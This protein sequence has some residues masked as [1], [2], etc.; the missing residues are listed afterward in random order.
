VNLSA[1]VIVGAMSG[2]ACGVF[3]GEYAAVLEP[4]GA[5]YVALLQ[6]VVFPFIVASLLHGLGSLR[7]RTAL[8]LLRSGWLVFVVAWAGTLGSLWLLAQA[9]PAGRSPIVVAADQGH[10]AAQLVSLLIPANPFADLTRNYVPAIVVFSVFYG[11][12]MQGI[13]KR[14]GVLRGLDVVRR[15]SVTIWS[16]VVRLAPLGVFA[17]FADLAGT[18]RLDLLGSLLL[19]AVLFVGGALILALWVIPSLIA[20]LVPIGYRALLRE[21][22]SA[23]LIAVVTSL[24]I[25][26]VPLIVQMSERLAARCRV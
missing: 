24:P 2:V 6:M 18:I 25:S 23:M 12:A 5:V 7:P 26:A 8:R 14:E 3:F 17:L 19:Y 16:W 11:I 15:A 22:R 4:I 10:G 21:L 1:W 20:S 9:V 13:E